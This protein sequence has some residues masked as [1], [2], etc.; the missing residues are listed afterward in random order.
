MSN[1]VVSF[2]KTNPLLTRYTQ[3]GLVNINSLSR[4]IKEKSKGVDKRSSVA[5]IGM[6]IRRFV[7]K[8]P[9]Q[10]TPKFFHPDIPLHIVTRTNL[11]E[12]IFD[13][14]GENRKLCLDLFNQISKTKSF[15]CLVEGEKEIVLLTD[16]SLSE[17]LNKEKIRG[18]V[19]HHTRDLGFI[20]IDFPISLREI[21]GVYNHITA[22]L[23]MVNIPIHSFHTIGGEILII[24]KN[25]DLIKTQEVL[26][27]SLNLL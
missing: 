20:S 25:K 11:Q 18:I 10:N 9:K 13:K 14:N 22:A 21:V 4:Y 17:F 6:E 27:S 2:F 5:A 24:V 19:S 7:A 1:T 12:L 3:I 23:V 26:T 8:L 15:S 16:Y